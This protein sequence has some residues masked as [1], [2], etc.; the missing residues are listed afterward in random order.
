MREIKQLFDTKSI[1]YEATF[2][3]KVCEGLFECLSVCV[4]CVCMCVSVCERERELVRRVLISD[5]AKGREP[6]SKKREKPTILF[7]N[8]KIVIW[9]TVDFCAHCKHFC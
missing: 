6:V 9:D 4:E 8:N 2:G 5:G 7:K 3:V 1:P